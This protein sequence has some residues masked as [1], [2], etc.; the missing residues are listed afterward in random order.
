MTPRRQGIS[1]GTRFRIFARDGFT[2]R[3][4][5]AQADTVTLVVDH[6]IP[7]KHG[8]TN[9][10]ENLVTACEPCNQGKA[11][12]QLDQSAPNDTDRLRL[13]QERNEQMQAAENARFIADAR[14][15]LRQTIVNFWCEE[16]GQK[17]MHTQTLDVMASFVNEHGFEIVADWIGI[18]HRRLPYGADYKLG[19]YISGIRRTLISEAKLVAGEKPPAKAA[20]TLPPPVR[21]ALVD[22][23][24]ED[25]QWLRD[26]LTAENVYRANNALLDDPDFDLDDDHDPMNVAL[27]DP[28]FFDGGIIE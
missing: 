4:C 15:D 23:P 14:R 3:Y 13:A 27:C 16:R 25:A 8:G 6:M 12:K 10:D 18:A 7:V 2:C 17:E 24:G 19:K 5:G 9:D 26:A 28:A 22:E 21:D 1:K 11:A 20:S